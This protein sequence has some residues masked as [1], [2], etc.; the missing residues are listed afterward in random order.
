MDAVIQPTLP[1]QCSNLSKKKDKN[2]GKET[3]S[4]RHSHFK[5]GDRPQSTNMMSQ[6]NYK[7]TKNS[8]RSEMG[9]LH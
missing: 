3:I 7:D 4:L 5:Y 2:K 1:T 9:F 8:Q 6:E